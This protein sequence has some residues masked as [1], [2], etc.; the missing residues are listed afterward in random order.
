MG[1]VGST[2]LGAIL[3]ALILSQKSI[4]LS[5]GILIISSPL[6]MDAST[7][8]IRRFFAGHNIFK[9]HKLHLFQRLNQSGW[10]HAKVSLTY[11]SATFLLCAGLLTKDIF[12]QTSFAILVIIFGVILEK[13][14]LPFKKV[15][16]YGK[17]DIS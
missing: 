13:F 8:V 15:L 3:A 9:P 6:L 11:F 16:D 10:S 4:M 5:A 17:E 12:I 14:A 2:F 7:S 1:D